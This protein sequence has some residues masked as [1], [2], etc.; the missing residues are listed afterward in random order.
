MIAAKAIRHVLAI[1]VM[2]TP[3]VAWGMMHAKITE[4]TLVKAVGKDESL[5]QNSMK[6]TLYLSL[7]ATFSAITVYLLLKQAA[8]KILQQHV[9]K[10]RLTFRLKAVKVP[11]H[12]TKFIEITSMT[13][14][15]LLVQTVGMFTNYYL[16]V[17]IL[18]HF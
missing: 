5:F 12:V 15:S 4:A 17:C 2:S 11:L 9:L 7:I 18:D 10:M 3:K 1:K 8:F 13:P 14:L 6:M 16:H